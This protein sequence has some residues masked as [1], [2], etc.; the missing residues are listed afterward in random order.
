MKDKDNNY[1]IVSD[2]SCDLPDELIKENNIK[3]DSFLCI[4][5][6]ECYLKERVNLQVRDFYEKM[7]NES[8]LNP[9]NYFTICSRL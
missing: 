1:V 5:R 2:S 7:V 9:E 4:A 6:W 3:V 8:N